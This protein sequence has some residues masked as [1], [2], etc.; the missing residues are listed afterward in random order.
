MS[1]PRPNDGDPPFD[2]LTSVIG[3]AD[4][5]KSFGLGCGFADPRLRNSAEPMA[6]ITCISWNSN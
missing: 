3:D 4:R 1:S 2:G 5:A 6:M